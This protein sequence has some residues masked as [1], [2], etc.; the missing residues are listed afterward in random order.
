M[1]K[2][3]EEWRDIAGFE[4]LYQISN[5]GRVRS[6]SRQ[7][8]RILKPMRSGE[9]LG[10]FLSNRGKP[11]RKYI[12]RLVAE[13]FMPTENSKLE[14]HHIDGDKHNNIVSNLVWNTRSEN[15]AYPYRVGLC[16][17]TEPTNSKK[18]IITFADGK[19]IICKSITSAANIL[20][21]SYRTIS[22]HCNDK[23]KTKR[24]KNYRVRFYG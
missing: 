20:M 12:Q 6:L 7:K 24:A 21:V 4:G 10:V 18:V 8:A 3:Q 9:Y 19:E 14:V 5:L 15:R 2:L 13:A 23:L 11:K 16:K 17:P 1:D 22:R